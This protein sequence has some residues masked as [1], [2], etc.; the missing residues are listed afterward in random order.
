MSSGRQLFIGVVGSVAI[1]AASVP[2][3]ADT[4]MWVNS[5]LSKRRTCPSIECGIVG[6]FFFRESV[7]VY[8]T[9]DG[10]SRVSRYYTAGCS[11]GRSAFVDFGRSDCVEENGIEDGK[12]AEWTRSDFLDAK[13]PGDPG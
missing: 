6:R 7:V 3:G 12:F 13:R 8:E 11:G 5:D 4:Q 1:L 10:W 2:A 9:S